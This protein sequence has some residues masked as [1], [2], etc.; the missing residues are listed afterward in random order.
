M[1]KKISV[2]LAFLAFASPSFAQVA[3]SRNGG[4]SGSSGSS[5]I[6]NGVTATSGCVAGG[7]LYSISNLVKCDGNF[8]FDNNI[9]TVGNVTTAGRSTIKLQ[10][11]ISGS[12]AT[13]NFLNI[14]IRFGS[15]FSG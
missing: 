14:N 2:V 13:S 8:T 3:M 7:V 4:G 10:D 5:T 15:Y 1:L 6:T 12:S 11:M 9:L